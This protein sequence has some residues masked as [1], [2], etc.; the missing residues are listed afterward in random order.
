MGDDVSPGWRVEPLEVGDPP[1]LLARSIELLE[2]LTTDP[3]PTLR[4]YRSTR[5]AIVLGR[6]QRPDAARGTKDVQVLVRHSGGGAVLLDPSLLSVD[7]ALPTGHPLLE[8]DL[9]AVFPRVGEAWRDALTDLGVADLRVHRGAG[10]AS[11]RGDERDRLL[12][13]V[14]YATVGRGEVLAGGRKLVGLAQR[15]RRPGALVQCGLLR[16]WD[17]AALL[18]ALGADPADREIA[19]AAVGL[20]DLLADAPSDGMVIEAVSSRLAG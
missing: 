7:V 15:R 1:V 12:A 19:E 14:C 17:P 18:T 11:H 13:A 9:S 4:W 5:T 8:G 20:D 10:T 3:R 2:G 16:S 6:G